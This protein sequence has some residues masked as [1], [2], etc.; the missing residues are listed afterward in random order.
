MSF[1]AAYKNLCILFAGSLTLHATA[2]I[3]QTAKSLPIVAIVGDSAGTELTDFVVPRAT[4]AQSGV[5]RVITV[6]A[7]RA[8]IALYPS[9]LTTVPEMTFAEFDDAFPRGASYVI[10]PALV[11]RNN[12]SVV[13]WIRQQAKDGATVAAIC[14]G[15]W[16]VARAGL[17][18]GHRAAGHWHSL[19][20]LA[21]EYPAVK[22]ERD[23]RYVF[24]DDRLSTAGV[25]ASLP[26]SLALVE[27]IGGREVAMSTAQKLG[28]SSWSPAHRTADFSVSRSMYARSLWNVV[29]WWRHES[30]VVP[31][32]D[33]V[34][35]IALAMTIDAIQRTG[36]AQ[37]Y[38]QIEGATTVLGGQGLRI[39]TVPLP[40]NAT[41]KA[42][43]MALARTNSPATALDSAIVQ[44]T[45][46]YGSGAGDIIAMGMEYPRHAMELT[47]K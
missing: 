19:G 24:D 5:A 8:S 17:L 12:P 46:W 26:F 23:T 10:V 7:T 31:V 34:D 18:D 45:R 30:I 16:T 13:A 44:L 20:A 6:S 22:W 11:A 33:G 9:T 38:A 3:A 39:Q 21:K 47:R 2:G 27:R 42:K 35:E 28:V 15:A 32:A 25:T 43:T 40:S 4:L 41:S 1:R 14:D 36:R 37:A 29:A